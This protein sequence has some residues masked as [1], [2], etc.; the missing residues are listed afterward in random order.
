MP[1]ANMVVEEQPESQQPG[2]AKS[3]MMGQDEAERTYDVGRNSPE[4][5]PL[6]QGFA[7]EPE[8]IVFEIA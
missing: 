2:W 8:L 5:L 6:D 1:A 4:D 7:D 3:I